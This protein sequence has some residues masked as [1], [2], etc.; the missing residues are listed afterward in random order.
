[1]ILVSNFVKKWQQRSKTTNLA[2]ILS[3]Q[4]LCTNLAVILNQIPPKSHVF[5]LISP[6]NQNLPAVRFYFFQI[7]LYLLTFS[8]RKYSVKFQELKLSTENLATNYFAK[9]SIIHGF[10]SGVIPLD[11]T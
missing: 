3:H 4:K 11:W 9:Y 2:V 6:E 8:D 1:M 10:T 7:N 5:H